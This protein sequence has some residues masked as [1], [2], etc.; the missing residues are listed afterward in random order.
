MTLSSGDFGFVRDLVRSRSAISL[1]LDKA[2]LVESR[3]APLAEQ[4]GFADLADLVAQ[5]RRAPFDALHQACVEAM[6]TNE[7]SFFRDFGVFE[8][9]RST[10]IPELLAARSAEKQ[11]GIW[12][13]GCSTGQEPYSIAMLLREHFPWLATW[14]VRILGTDLSRRSLEQARAARYSQLEVNR[15]LPAPLLVRYFT[16]DGPWW[17]LREDVRRAVEFQPLNL[18]DSWPP[19]PPMDLVLLRNVLIYFDATAKIEILK[20]VRQRL[21]PDAALV[22]G[23][24]ESTLNLDPAFT[25]IRAGRATYYRPVVAA[26]GSDA[27][28][29]GAPVRREARGR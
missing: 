25:P 20:R 11:L 19:L 29:L 26:S 5:L 12:C 18:I 15:G 2:Y 21:R 17:V 3:L 14:R 8:A 22:L 28:P 13:A 4:A 27:Q 16:Q 7:T 23:G 1:S 9:L 10:V 6:A 24:V